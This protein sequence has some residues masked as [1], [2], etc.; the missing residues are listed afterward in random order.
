MHDA[1]AMG[2]AD[3]VG[4]L[5]Q[6]FQPVL[7]REFMAAGREI[8]VEANGLWVEVFEEQGRAKFVLFVILNRKNV[9]VVEGLDDLKFA[10]GGSF[11]SLAFFLGIGLRD[12]VLPDAAEYVGE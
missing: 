4:N 8:V 2:I 3:R 5:T 11:A 9:W 7:G 12:G 1:T 6:Q 10:G